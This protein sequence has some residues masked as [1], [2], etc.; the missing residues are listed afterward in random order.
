MNMWEWVV[1]ITASNF[2]L[3]VLPSGRSYSRTGRPSPDTIR[4][5]GV[6]RWTWLPWA[7]I[8]SASTS[9]NSPKLPMG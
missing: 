9:K 3:P 1:A 2:S 4:V 7:L 6:D 5:T 8:F